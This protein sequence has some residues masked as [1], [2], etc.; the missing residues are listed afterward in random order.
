MRRLRSNARLFRRLAAGVPGLAVV[1]GGEGVAAES[2]VVHL[3]L[4]PA[5]PREKVGRLQ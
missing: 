2:P 3:A 4:H 1:G 5:P